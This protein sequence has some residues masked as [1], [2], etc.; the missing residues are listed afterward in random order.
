MTLAADLQRDLV[1]ANEELEAIRPPTSWRLSRPLRQARSMQ[2]HREAERSKRTA[3]DGRSRTVVPP[4]A[5][6]DGW[7]VRHRHGRRRSPRRSP[8]P[9]NPPS[10][11]RPAVWPRRVGHLRRW[12]WPPAS[13]PPAHS[14]PMT[15][16]IATT[17]SP[18]RPPPRRRP[19]G[20]CRPLRAE[21]PWIDPARHDDRVAHVDGGLRLRSRRGR[22]RRSLVAP[23]AT[24]PCF[25]HGLGVGR[26]AHALRQGGVDPPPSSRTGRVRR[27]RHPHRGQRLPHR[28]PRVVRET[29]SR[30]WAEEEIVLFGWNLSEKVPVL[31]RFV[32]GRALP[33]MEGPMRSRV[34]PP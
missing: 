20:R 9:T 2:L 11:R 32:R 16:P 28:R 30:W 5:S 25:R 26:A 7:P 17:T 13:R 24:W 12:A 6:G 14:S 18:Q 27:R 1:A 8:R 31:S 10:A 22:A 3:G 4:A 29:V 33:C 19:R 34:P 21:P 23:G 15:P